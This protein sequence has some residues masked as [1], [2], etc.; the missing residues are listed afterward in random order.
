MPRYRPAVRRLESSAGS[1]S[2]SGSALAR[3]AVNGFARAS[4]HGYARRRS[5]RSTGLAVPEKSTLSMK[6]RPGGKL[7]FMYFTPDSTF[8]LVQAR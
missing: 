3:E 7:P 2:R 6:V 8:P 5:R 4:Y 1:R